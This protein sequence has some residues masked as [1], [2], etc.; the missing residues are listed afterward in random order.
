MD[1]KRRYRNI[2]NECV[3]MLRLCYV[4]YVEEGEETSC[5]MS[6]LYLVGLS[7]EVHGKTETDTG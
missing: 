7:D 6:P 1:L 5:L 2:L 4:V 3:Y